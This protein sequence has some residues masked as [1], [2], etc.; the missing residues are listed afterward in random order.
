[1]L[2]FNLVQTLEDPRLL[3]PG[4]PGPRLVAAPGGAEQIA[5]PLRRSA[6]LA[7]GR[8][9]PRLGQLRRRSPRRFLRREA[10]ED[11]VA[12]FLE[13][14]KTLVPAAAPEAEIAPADEA[15]RGILGRRLAGGVPILLCFGRFR[16]QFPRAVGEGDRLRRP[17]QR[18]GVLRERRRPLE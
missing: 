8:F 1:E 13:E 10:F 12:S 7:L 3:K 18:I 9:P 2:G 15:S 14:G 17:G 11:R 6:L 4:R 16:A 5:T